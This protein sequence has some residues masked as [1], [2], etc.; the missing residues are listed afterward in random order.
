MAFEIFG[1]GQAKASQKSSQAFTKI[2]MQ[3]RHQWEVQDLIK[4]GLNPILSAHGTPSMGS[5]PA[6]IGPSLAQEVTRGMEAAVSTAGKVGTLKSKIGTAAAGTS[7]AKSA[8]TTAAGVAKASKWA[9]HAAE[10]GFRNTQEQ[11][12][13]HRVEADIFE[14]KKVPA[15]MEAARDYERAKTEHEFELS[16]TGKSL[17]KWQYGIG[18]TINQSPISAGVH[19]VKGLGRGLMRGKRGLPR[20]KIWKGR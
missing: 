13:K 19:A 16:P 9:P 17:R 10:A 20:K 11:M 5:S 8:A 12:R 14:A 6:P 4:A 1:S 7:T 3:K 15:T 2:M 18:A